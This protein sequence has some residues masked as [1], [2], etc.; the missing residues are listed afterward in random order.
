MMNAFKYMTS[1]K[2]AVIFHMVLQFP[3][4]LTELIAKI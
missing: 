2:S 1:D 4:H 3:L